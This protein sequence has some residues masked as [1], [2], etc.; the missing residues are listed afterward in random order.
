MQNNQLDSKKLNKK[1]RETNR[2]WR[3]KLSTPWALQTAQDRV[4]WRIRE[5]ALIISKVYI[6]HVSTKQG[7]QGAEY[8]RNFQ[9]D[10]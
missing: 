8:N 9:K 4:I 2:R 5:E 7:I 6:A 1:K 3:D 10:R